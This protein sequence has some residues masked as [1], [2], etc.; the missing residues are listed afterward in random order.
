[1][2]AAE[3]PQTQPRVQLLE[4]PAIAPLGVQ[5]PTPRFV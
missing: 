4:P 5:C 1:M 3:L 2:P